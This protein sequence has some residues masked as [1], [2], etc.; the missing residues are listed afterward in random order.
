MFPLSLVLKKPV[1]YYV[2]VTKTTA[3]F[4]SYNI[5]HLMNLLN[6][7]R[8]AWRNKSASG[9]LRPGRGGLLPLCWLAIGAPLSEIA[10]GGSDVGRTWVP[11][12]SAPWALDGECAR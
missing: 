8:V 2:M 11:P 10:L 3:L 1:D 4:R 9:D 6:M 12:L 5:T 7:Q